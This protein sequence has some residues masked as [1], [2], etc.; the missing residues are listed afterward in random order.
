MQPGEDGGP[1]YWIPNVDGTI[2]AGSNVLIK[3]ALGYCTSTGGPSG[4][5]SDSYVTFGGGGAFQVLSQGNLAV[6][7]Q[8]ALT[9]FSYDG[10]SE[11]VVPVTAN[12]VIGT[13]GLA[14]FFGMAGLQWTRDSFDIAG[15]GSGSA[16]DTDPVVGAGVLLRGFAVG[17]MLKFGED[18]AGGSSTDLALNGSFQLSLP[19]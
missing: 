17:V 15:I 13:G 3:G 2:A 16:T 6:N 12:A 8:A 7:I 9:A 10:G 18:G 1:T 11:Q 14:S 19:G 5:D 4:F